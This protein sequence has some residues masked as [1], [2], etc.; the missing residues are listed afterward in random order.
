MSRYDALVSTLT[1][2]AAETTSEPLQFGEAMDSLDTQAYPFAATIITLPFLQPFPLGFFALIGTAA[3]CALGWQ[4]YHNKTTLSLPDKVRKV[5][6][7]Q[8]VRKAMVATC[9]K[10]LG[11]LSKFSKARLPFLLTGLLGKKIGGFIFMSVGVLLAIP[12]GGVIPFKNLF[13]SLAIL[14]YCTGEVKEDGLMVIMAFICLLLT[15]V[16]YGLLFFLF[17]KF[18]AAAV[19]QYLWLNN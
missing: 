15:I 16:F 3:Y 4:L 2:F 8:S 13:P 5:A 7:K 1:H 12:L 14:F 17:W 6:I 19:Q 9:L 10:I 18:G 11:F